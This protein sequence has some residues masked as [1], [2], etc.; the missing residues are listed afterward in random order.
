MSGAGGSAQ[1]ALTAVV[2]EIDIY[3]PLAG[4]VDIEQEIKR[5]AKEVAKLESELK[6]AEGKLQNQGFLAKA[7]QH[8]VEQEKAKAE[9]YRQRLDKVQE[10]LQMLR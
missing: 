1:A 6:R 2:K 5:L 4:L 9:D 10:R 8:V 3:L 7:P